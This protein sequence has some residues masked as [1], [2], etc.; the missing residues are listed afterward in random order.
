MASL[1]VYT[2]Q[3]KKAGSKA[4][5]LFALS[6]F[7]WTFL[8]VPEYYSLSFAPRAL[9]SKL[10]YLGIVFMPM[11][12][13]IFTLRYTRRDAW[14]NK[15]SLAALALIPSASLVFA[16]TDRWHGLIWQ[17]ASYTNSPFPQLLIEHGLWF[18]FVLVPYTYGLFALG[19][20]VLL[21]SFLLDSSL[22]R[23]Q[24][25]LTLISA[26]FPLMASVLYL[27][28]D[29]LLYGLDPTPYGFAACV[30]LNTYGLFR[31]D[32]LAVTPVSY[33]EVFLNT[34]NSVLLVNQDQ[35]IIDINPA[36]LNELQLDAKNVLG[37]AFGNFYPDFSPLL[38]SNSDTQ[39]NHTLE[40]EQETSTRHTELKIS[41]IFN[42]NS[43]TGQVIIMRDVTLERE[44]QAKL[45]LFAYRDSLTG[46]ANRHQ[47][48]LEAERAFSLANRYG[49]HMSMLYID[50]DKFKLIND[51]Y[52]H[53]MGD[54]V[55]VYVAKCLRQTM[56]ENDVVARIGGDEFAVLLYEAGLS[57]THEARE[58]LEEHLAKPFTLNQH[59]FSVNASVGFALYP[60]HGQ[61]LSTLLR[62]ADAAMYQVKRAKTANP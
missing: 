9:F 26:G 24:T 47:L 48:K 57:E 21:T 42:S 8:A 32:Q 30:A 25:G 37:K 27:L 36:A 50:L 53:E 11:A 12:W 15:R 13:F 41:P 3:Q 6:I 59:S 28:S 35:A 29:T 2:W 52:G 49:V 40:L 38:N 62:H 14:L 56:R 10:Q 19:V 44:Q 20:F 22:Y 4:F 60:Q 1:C 16:F 61:D 58:R 31:K 55:L 54:E 43:R 45:E 51:Q 33:R 18:R 46:I 5:S 34:P 7:I 39:H 23:R 17:S